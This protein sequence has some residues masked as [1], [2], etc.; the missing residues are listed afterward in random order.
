VHTE[1]GRIT[2]GHEECLGSCGTA[3]VLR[4]DGVYH[5]DLDLEQARSLIDALE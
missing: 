2:I 4:I 1:D 3:P 5:E